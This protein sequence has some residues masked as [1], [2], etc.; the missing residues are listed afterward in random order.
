MGRCPL[1]PVGTPTSYGCTM[2][3]APAPMV[4]ISDRL[5]S[6][7]EARTIT[8]VVAMFRAAAAVAQQRGDETGAAAFETWMLTAEFVERGDWRAY[9]PKAGA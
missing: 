6:A 8:A 1:H 2:C 7:V 3:A 5:T 4:P 9:L